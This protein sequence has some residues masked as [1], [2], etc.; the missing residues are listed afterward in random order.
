MDTTFQL[1][2]RNPDSVLTVRTPGEEREPQVDLGET[3]LQAEVV[4]Q[5]D[6]DT[7]HRLWLGELVPAVALANGDI[8]T[9]GPV[10]KILGLVPLVEPGY[11]R[12]RTAA[13]GVGRERTC[14][15]SPPDRA[16][17]R[18][19]PGRLGLQALAGRRDELPEGRGVVHAGEG[20][21][22]PGE[23]ERHAR[24]AHP[25]RD[26]LLGGDLALAVGRRQGRAQL[27]GIE[28]GRAVGHE[29]EH[30]VEV[31][32]VAAVAEVAG[33]RAIRASR[34]CPRR[35]GGATA[36]DG[37]GACSGSASIRSWR[38]SRPERAPSSVERSSSS[39]SASTVA[40]RSG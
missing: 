32:D 4:L 17:S 12:Y 8:R 34:P 26:A 22:A 6:A 2:L 37:P 13:Q 27:T 7:A 29:R 33:E 39:R 38:S 24:E 19:P 40:K 15:T 1:R 23:E 11:T 28:A 3:T 31:A 35:V 25:R 9:R 20:D 36:G 16:G 30:L 10:S 18:A 21:A 14:F 5:L